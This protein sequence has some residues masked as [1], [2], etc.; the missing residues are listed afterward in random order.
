MAQICRYY[1]LHLAAIFLS[2]I[3]WAFY[4]MLKLVFGEIS[5]YAVQQQGNV[6]Y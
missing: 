3:V 1:I 6:H 4:Y 5:L 2:I